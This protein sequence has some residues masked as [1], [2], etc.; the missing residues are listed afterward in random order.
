VHSVSLQQQPRIELADCEA[1]WGT[2]W[3]RSSMGRGM[4][5]LRA[6]GWMDRSLKMVS[7][8]RGIAFLLL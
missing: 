1:E 2:G 8:E 5:K 3:G 4:R 6:R 7:G